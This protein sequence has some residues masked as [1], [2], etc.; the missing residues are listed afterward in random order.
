MRPVRALMCRRAVAIALACVLGSATTQGE[1]KRPACTVD[2]VVTI[3]DPAS[4]VASIE[5]RLD[6]AARP[7]PFDL[8][9]T[10]VDG[11]YT[12]GYA[13]FVADV[14]LADADGV[15][16]ALTQAAKNRWRPPSDLVDG[17]YT[18]TYVVRVDH[19]AEPSAWGL[20][21]TPTLAADGGVLIG[22]ALFVLPSPQ[23][24]GAAPPAEW[25][26]GIA[27][28]VAWQLPAG[29]RSATAWP[30]ATAVLARPAS[31][32]DLLNNFVL[33]TAPGVFDLFDLSLGG[34]R[35]T[36]AV[37]HGA[38][39]FDSAELW[40]GFE[41]SIRQSEAVFGGMPS[42]QYLLIVNPMPGT[43]DD[44]SVLS[45][46]GGAARQSFHAMLDQKRTGADL[47]GRG[48]LETIAHET[49]HWWNP[50]GLPPAPEA[51]FYWWHE[52]I[53]VYYQDLVL[54]R[55]GLIS[56]DDFFAHLSA[57]YDRGE[58]RNQAR[59]NTSLLEASRKIAGEGGA[60][61][62]IVYGLGAVFGLALDVEIR[63]R[64]GGAHS[65][66][67]LLRALYDR[68]SRTGRA[69][70]YDDL[71]AEA[72]R[73]ADSDLRPFFAAYVEGHSAY[74]WPRLLEVFGYAEREVATGRPMMG[75]SYDSSTRTATIASTVPGAPA[76]G[77]LKSG[78]VIRGI[79]GVS[80]DTA[81]DLSAELQKR[82]PGDRVTL[83]VDRGGAVTEVTLTLANRQETRTLPVEKP[84]PEARRLL[85]LL[86]DSR[87]TKTGHTRL[88]REAPAAQHGRRQRSPAA[89]GGRGAAKE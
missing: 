23:A 2:Y 29:W 58:R 84:T 68:H 15:A 20:K 32:D 47:E 83:K 71:V 75:V 38:W 59:P 4:R 52:G 9:I 34:S 80:I 65:L 36:G 63:R 73:L 10:D 81:A 5:A 69:F 72:S 70:A 16:V 53:S 14:R 31:V 61:Y 54:W 67:D 39:S 41:R 33:V 64:S 22:A 85:A 51:D 43:K 49:F 66:D 48:P 35:V 11:H 24:S 88:R 62:D 57:Q 21:E 19:A 50:S 6:F 76:D 79:N 87:S 28:S 37:R 30:A 56:A 55:A 44:L 40:S 12:P 26:G 46:G 18:L 60:E 82:K 42:R 78:D 86:G 1:T 13:K 17:R 89:Y 45:D 27:L 3:R 74:D 8:A 77:L 7:G 25:P